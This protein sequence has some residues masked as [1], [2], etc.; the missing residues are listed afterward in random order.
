MFLA[1]GIFGTDRG[2]GSDR[3]RLADAAHVYLPAL[4]RNGQ[5][6]GEHLLGWSKGHLTVYANAASSGFWAERFL[7]LRT[8][9]NRVAWCRYARR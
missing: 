3:E 9:P 4:L 5:I 2:C 8:L 6:L 7:S 1:R